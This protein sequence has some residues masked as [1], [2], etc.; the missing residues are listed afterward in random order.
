MSYYVYVLRSEV[1][2][3]SYVG[4]TNNLATRLTQHNNGNSISTRSKRP[5]KLVYQEEFLTR[6]EA[7]KRER[8]FKTVKG[9]I[10]LKSRGII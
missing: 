6:S 8:Y 9:R 10:E 2:D 5:W 3:S 1:A 7:M 4:H